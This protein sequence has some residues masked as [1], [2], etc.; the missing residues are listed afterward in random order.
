MMN[1]DE[2]KA[3]PSMRT[4]NATAFS[5]MSVVA[6]SIIFGRTSGAFVSLL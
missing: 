1:D 4:M 6:M 5:C 2:R 3:G